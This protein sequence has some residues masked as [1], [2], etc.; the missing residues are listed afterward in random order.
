MVSEKGF[1]TDISGDLDG[2]L[3]CNGDFEI[4]TTLTLQL[5]AIIRLQGLF[6]ED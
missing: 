6:V 5:A 1:H 3:I 4:E 2:E